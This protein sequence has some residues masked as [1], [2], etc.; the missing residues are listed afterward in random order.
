MTLLDAISRAGGLSESAG[1]E[2]LVS[3]P[4][5]STS[6]TSVTLTERIPVRALYNTEDPASNITLEGGENIRVPGA[7]QVF[8]VG[9]V[10]HPGPFLITNGSE[11]SVLKAISYSE[12]LDSYASHRAYIY[13][14]DGSSGLKSEIPV[15]LKKIL[16]RKSP[17]V[18]LFANDMLYVPNATGARA[19][20]KALEMSL[21]MGL[22]LAGVLVA[23]TR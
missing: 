23:V 7:G 9:N 18:P 14:T 13:R 15:D 16:A 17:D 1:A 19:G 10:K 4:P 22:G 6:G 3:R 20:A 11:T 5:S 8:V 12:G 2:I 21:A